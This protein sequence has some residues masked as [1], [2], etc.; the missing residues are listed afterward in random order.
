MLWN[1]VYP[2]TPTKEHPMIDQVKFI[3]ELKFGGAILD[4]R[5]PP[6]LGLGAHHQKILIICGG[7]GTI[8]FSGGMDLVYDRINP[9]DSPSYPFHDVQCKIMGPATKDLLDIFVERW[10]DHPEHFGKEKGKFIYLEDQYLVSK[11][12][13]FELAG[14]L[15]QKGFEFLLILVPSDSHKDADLP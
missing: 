14:K 2:D 5:H 15:Q 9:Y 3:N 11:E 4:S 1:N 7:L 10:R 6:L 13:A 8:A 12:M